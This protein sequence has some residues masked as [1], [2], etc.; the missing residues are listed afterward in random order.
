MKKPTRLNS[1]L[2]APPANRAPQRFTVLVFGLASALAF[3]ACGTLA[4]LRE[5][6]AAL[7]SITLATQAEAARLA[8]DAL[9]HAETTFASG[10]AN[11]VKEKKSP[12][13]AKAKSAYKT[14]KTSAD[15]AIRLALQA[16]INEIAA[17]SAKLRPIATVTEQLSL[18]D[19]AN[20]ERVI[21][22]NTLE[23]AE[24]P[25]SLI[26]I[27][28]ARKLLAQFDIT[29]VAEVIETTEHFYTVKLNPERR[30][31]LWRIAEALLSDAWRWRE[32][33]ELNSELLSNP[34][35]IHPGQE[36]QLPRN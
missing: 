33:Y 8:Q 9:S 36:L 24:Y 6:E 1:P 29:A 5:R 34:H 35:L 26:A 21:A 4:P 14:A 12:K 30:D 23:L 27:E 22:Q 13:N 28:A 17:L 2:P 19:A 7:S 18:L 25:A 32:I 20:A 15:N 11:I 10:E 16:L 3:S 31:C